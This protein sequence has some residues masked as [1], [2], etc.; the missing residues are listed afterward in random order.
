MG[1]SC[2]TESIR[3]VIFFCLLLTHSLSFALDCDVTGLSRLAIQQ[4]AIRNATFALVQIINTT[5]SGL[6]YVGS[7]FLI[8]ENGLLITNYHVIHDAKSIEIKHFNSGN[9]YPT[10]RIRVVEYDPIRDLAVLRITGIEYANSMAPLD[11]EN[12]HE[13]VDGNP[14]FIVV[15]NSNVT[16]NFTTKGIVGQTDYISYVI[17][18]RANLGTEESNPYDYEIFLFRSVIS[19]GNSGAPLL[20]IDTAK[21]IGIATGA[22]G[23]EAYAGFAIPIKYAMEL[24]STSHDKMEYT[25]DELFVNGKIVLNSQDPYYQRIEKY[26]A[27][28]YQNLISVSGNLVEKYTGEPIGNATVSL[29]DKYD[30]NLSFSQVTNE[31]GDYGFTIPKSPNIQWRL[32]IDHDNYVLQ[33]LTSIDIGTIIAD[34]NGMKHKMVIKKEYS[35]EA[36]WF[37]ISP[38]SVDLEYSA[39]TV[40]IKN[41]YTRWGVPVRKTREID[42]CLCE[43]FDECDF[44]KSHKWLMVNSSKGKAKGRGGILKLM[45]SGTKVEGISPELLVDDLTVYSKEDSSMKMAPL[46]V[47]ADRKESDLLFIHG[48]VTLNTGGVPEPHTVTITAYQKDNAGNMRFKIPVDIDDTGYFVLDFP[49]SDRDEKE[50]LF[51]QITSGVYSDMSS[52]ERIINLSEPPDKPIYFELKL[53]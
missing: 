35:K 11:I 23:K 12:C 1:F 2:V 41:E 26:S 3:I 51:L 38:L 44:N 9:E 8:G 24:M 31:N 21:I 33:N 25:I 30:S 6:H 34:K 48:F 20:N 53:K 47:Y 32:D 4:K 17:P 49:H 50:E 15:A 10:E 43:N 18:E 52:D 7:G 14:E 45:Y 16:R 27:I 13:E 19:E 39:K 46:Y 29:S 5:R 36:S 40:R 22:A 42:W 28:S 37:Y